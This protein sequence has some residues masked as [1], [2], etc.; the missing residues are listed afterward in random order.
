MKL[1]SGVL[2][3]LIILCRFSVVSLAA[4][5]VSASA[6]VVIN[7]QTGTVL[8]SKNSNTRLAM[9]S[10]TK[11]MTALLLC[12]AGQLDK[13]LKITEEMVRVEGTSMG[14]TPG[15]T[16]TRRDLLYGMLLSSGNDA[17]NAAAVS[18]AGNVPAFVALMNRKAVALGLENTHF[19]TPSGLDGQNHYTTAT[20]LALLARY[21][22]SNDDF[23][24]ACSS[25]MKSLYYG[26]PPCERTLTNHNKL[27]K[28]YDGLIGVK[29][30]FTKKAGRC[31]VTAAE[32]N[33]AL[34]IAVTLNA[35]D[36][37][38]DHRQMLD[39]GFSNLE[40]INLAEYNENSK[41]FVAGTKDNAVNIEAQPLY[42]WLSKSEQEN[43]SCV[44]FA[45]SFLYP[46]QNFGSSIGRTDFYVDGHFIGSSELVVNGI[47][48]DDMS[49]MGL[50]E[51]CVNNFILLIKGM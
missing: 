51:R 14:L 12:E 34:V 39:F 20:E 43:I 35:P 50:F 9:A 17:A 27:L 45:P 36:D 33:G 42:V 41:I 37:W 10:T 6:A 25:K 18:V 21:A 26:D 40:K 15:I 24:E 7:G 11:I 48:Y 2:A 44:N 49:D 29:T 38:N 47:A 19:E 16:V 30:G 1:I 31:L 3:F 46:P 4:P 23:K 22:L 32:R 8:Y 28:S 13:E 5:S